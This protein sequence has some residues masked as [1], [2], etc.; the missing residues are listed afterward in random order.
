M[1][2]ALFEMYV[3]G[4]YNDDCFFVSVYSKEEKQFETNSAD[5]MN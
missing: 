4:D 3:V 2:M 1:S 5:E